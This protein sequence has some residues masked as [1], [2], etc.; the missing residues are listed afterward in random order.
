MDNPLR[1]WIYQPDKL[2]SPYIRPGMT[3]L[4]IGCGWGVN[5]LSLAR[6]TGPEGRVIAVDIQEKMLQALRRRALRAGLQD[7]IVARR[8]APDSIGV[9]EH[10]DFAVAFWVMHE[11]PDALT[12]LKQLQPRI[13]DSGKFLVV[14]PKLEVSEEAFSRFLELLPAAGFQLVAQPPISA[15]RTALLAR[16]AVA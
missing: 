12:L 10:I 9:T 5:S 4:D 14:E 6:L 13:A 3:A 2:F 8:C 11:V 16:A 15:S 7:R 1:R